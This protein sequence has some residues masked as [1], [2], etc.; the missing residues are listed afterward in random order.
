LIYSFDAHRFPQGGIIVTKAIIALLRA[1]GAFVDGNNDAACFG[2]AHD[3]PGLAV[4]KGYMSLRPT[5][6]SGKYAA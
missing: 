4:F 1:L 5:R 2:R 3:D 6:Q